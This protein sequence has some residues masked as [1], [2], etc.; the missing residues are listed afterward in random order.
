MRELLYSVVKRWQGGDI[1]HLQVVVALLSVKYK[2]NVR[3]VRDVRLI[4]DLQSC[5]MRGRNLSW[6]T[7]LP[8]QCLRASRASARLVRR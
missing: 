2:V 3:Y 6:Q 7:F 1:R 5:F 8:S 4:L